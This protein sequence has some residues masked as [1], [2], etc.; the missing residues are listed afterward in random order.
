M[1][2]T[3]NTPFGSYVLLTGS[4]GM[5]LPGARDAFRRAVSEHAD[6]LYADEILATPSGEKRLFK[7][8][9]SPD[10]LLSWPYTG[11]P[12]AIRRTLYDACRADSGESAEDAAFM[13]HAF[14]KAN[15]PLHV[16]SF[17]LK[18][19]CMPNEAA[20]SRIRMLKSKSSDI[21]VLPGL[22]PG[23]IQL[24]Y[25]IPSDA[26]L[27]VLVWD[28]SDT[29][30]LR[31]TL[32]SLEL[33]S[34]SRRPE[35]LLAIP[36]NAGEK[37]RIYVR[38]LVRNHAVRL[39]NANGIEPITAC[40]MNRGAE[41]ATGRVLLFLRAGLELITHDSLDRLMELALREEIGTVGCKLL[42]QDHR[43]LHCGYFLGL[44][45]RPETLYYGHR[46]STRF[47]IQNLYTNCI[48]NVSAAGGGVLA[49][50]RSVFLE[51]G[52]FDKTV[53]RFAYEAELGI[54]LGRAHKRNVYQPYAVFL[55]KSVRKDEE[56][57][58][59]QKKRMSDLMFPFRNAGDPML[60]RN[61]EILAI[62]RKQLA[63]S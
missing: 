47:A 15:Q 27:S 41:N 45:D 30:T 16:A 39:I 21:S 61:P 12:I 34:T 18:G 56:P 57:T 35:I 8:D 22:F 19:S 14:Q 3:L 49:V 60:S 28:I 33:K 48:R 32:E 37:L 20:D 50:R 23:S 24:R 46:D 11:F 1:M 17:L 2:E 62:Y 51:S 9:W 29:E 10:T 4:S 25:P 42:S 55:D 54:R 59:Q 7:P 6:L 38:E 53:P 63:G 31:R 52:G 26:R 44:S 13:L 58:S 36:E 5:L 40:L 43:I